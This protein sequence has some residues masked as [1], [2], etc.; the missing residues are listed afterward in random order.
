MRSI[1]V[2]GAALAACA[3]SF[4]LT[5]VPTFQDNAVRTWSTTEK[6]VVNQAISDWSSTIQSNYTINVTL[7]FTQVGTSSYVGQWQGQVSY[8]VGDDVMP[9]SGVTHRIH[10]N[11]DYL[12]GTHY[13]WFDPTPTTRDDIPFEAWD[14]V[15]VA[16]HEIGHMLGFSTL[17]RY[18]YGAATEVKAWES[19]I[20]NVGGN[21]IFDASTLNVRLESASLSHVYYDYANFNWSNPPTLMT[22]TLYNSLRTD[23]GVS[24]MQ[25]LQSAYGY[26]VPEPGVMGLL[27]S[28]IMITLGR[29]QRKSA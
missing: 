17:Y 19:H 28:S 1:L 11:A 18:D 23:I 2:L 29:R 6:A 8:A 9:W 26:A 10:F 12:T 20:T 14:A 7:D 24:D 5:I 15:T 27:A 16:R 3:N 13:L 25:M 22:T 21:Q 4:A